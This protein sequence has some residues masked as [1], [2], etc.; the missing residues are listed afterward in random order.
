MWRFNVCLLCEQVEPMM[1]VPALSLEALRPHLQYV[2]YI[3]ARHV[4]FQRSTR[5]LIGGVSGPPPSA[6]SR[7]LAVSRIV[8]GG[9]ERNTS[10]PERLNLRI[11]GVSIS[12]FQQFL[13]LPPKSGI[14]RCT[15]NATLSLQRA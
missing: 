6:T 8:Y 1:I 3:S 2:R 9:P 12:T 10:R 11:F 15:F 13:S 7:F 5:D 14:W 4:A